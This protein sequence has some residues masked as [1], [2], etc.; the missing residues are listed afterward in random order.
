MLTPGSMVLEDDTVGDEAAEIML[1]RDLER[2]IC[3]AI[4]SRFLLQLVGLL[5]TNISFRSELFTS[6]GDYIHFVLSKLI[7]NYAL[8]V[9]TNL[10]FGGISVSSSSHDGPDDKE[11]AAVGAACA[12]LH[13]TFNTLPHERIMTALAYRTELVPVLWNFMKRCHDYQK[14]SSLSQQFAYLSGDAPGWLL[15]LAVFCPVYK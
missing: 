12:F 5:D 1:N 8:L 9:Q 15:P 7:A 2:Q 4:D 3:N 6:I 13:V 11:V 14:W 10:L